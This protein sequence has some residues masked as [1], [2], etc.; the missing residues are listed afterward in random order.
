MT[1]TVRSIAPTV[2]PERAKGGTFT[3]EYGFRGRREALEWDDAPIGTA[4]V[5]EEV[6]MDLS[7]VGRNTVYRVRDAAGATK[8]IEYDIAHIDAQKS[9]G[10]KA[11]YTKIAPMTIDGLPSARCRSFDYS[12]TRYATC[13]VAVGRYVSEYTAAQPAIVAQ[14]T[15][16]AYLV[17]RHAR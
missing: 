15:A 9:L 16:A 17:L 8:L 10:D 13:Y 2:A 3:S 7:G 6:G 4:K 12:D 11:D 1:G 14:V 5:F